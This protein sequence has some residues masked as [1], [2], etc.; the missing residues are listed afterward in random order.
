MATKNIVPRADGEGSIGTSAKK[1]GNVYADNITVTTGLTASTFTGDLTGD[2]TGNVTGNVTGDLVGDVTG[3]VTGNVTGNVT[4]DVTGTASGNLA[5]TG[6]TM[7]G[8]IVFSGLDA[9]G[10]DSAI[11]CDTD[12]DGIRITG[13]TAGDKGASIIVYGKDATNS[14]GCFI[15]SAR[16]GVNTVEL[17]GRPNGE[18]TWNNALLVPTGVV[19]AFAGSTTPAGWLLC[20]GSAVSRTDYAALFAVIGTTYGSGDGSTTFN[21][22][23]L[24]DKFIEGSSTSGTEKTAGLPNITGTI[25]CKTNASGYYAGT[26]TTGAFTSTGTKGNNMG[27]STGEM[28]D[29]PRQVNLNASLSSSIYGSST[30]V[31]PPALTM[32]YIIKT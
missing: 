4:G 29:A 20:D 9:H 19:Q 30:T 17:K 10:G 15:H 7:T 22:P 8:E 6:G 27:T 1:W 21:L 24:T 12:T 13:A 3:D 18:L 28:T 5:L 2:V 32:R 11:Q 26:Y 25:Q 16:D 31:Q 23:N 14:A